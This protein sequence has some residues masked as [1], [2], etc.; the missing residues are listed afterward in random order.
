MASHYNC[1]GAHLLNYINDFGGVASS[2]A[3]AQAKFNQLQATLDDLGLVPWRLN[4][5]PP[6]PPSQHMTWLGLDFD[7]VLMTITIHSSKLNESADIVT[8][9][10]ARSHVDLHALRVLLGKLL[11]LTQC[12]P[13]DGFFLNRM[14]DTLRASPRIHTADT[15]V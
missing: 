7:T 2:K 14:L 10:Q 8:G 11:N 3:E 13:P 12:C 5:R 9:W 1:K 4:T 6:P 15:G